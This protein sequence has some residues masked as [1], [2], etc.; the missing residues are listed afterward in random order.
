MGQSEVA[1]PG[2]SFRTGAYSTTLEYRGQFDVD[3]VTAATDAANLFTFLAMVGA[4]ERRHEAPAFADAL[5]YPLGGYAEMVAPFGGVVS[6]VAGLGDMVTE[7]QVLAHVTDPMTR[8]RAA[9]TAPFAG[10]M[11][12]RELWR[13]C[14]RGQGLCHVAGPKVRRDGHLLS[15]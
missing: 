13:H 9:I 14:L 15:D 1:V 7:G 10:M 6:W 3:D 8:E 5:T 12:R 4:V 2:S 11:F